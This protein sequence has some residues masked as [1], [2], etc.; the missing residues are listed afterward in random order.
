MVIHVCD[1]CVTKYTS[2]LHTNYEHE[3]VSKTLFS[4]GPDKSLG[5]YKFIHLNNDTFL[6]I[7]TQRVSKK[8]LIGNV[9]SLCLFL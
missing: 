4:I 8:Y 7:H 2:I 5:R 1:K 6:K 3:H 9:L